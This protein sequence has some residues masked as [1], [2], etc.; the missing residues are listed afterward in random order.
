LEK[1]LGDFSLENIK[2]I[3]DIEIYDTPNKQL[4]NDIVQQ[5][6]SAKEKIYLE[7]YIFTEKRIREALKRA[8]TR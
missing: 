3:E 7:V 1:Q 5:I 4:L 6:D 2:E 8:Q